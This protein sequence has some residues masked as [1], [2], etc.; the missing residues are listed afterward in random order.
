M[1]YD[2]NYDPELEQK[3]ITAAKNSWADGLILAP[4]ANSQNREFYKKVA[5]SDR[6]HFPAISLE[7]DLVACG[8]DSVLINGRR[9]AYTATSHLLELDCRSILHIQSPTITSAS[10]ERFSGV[11]RC[12]A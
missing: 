2:S 3:Y 5:L 9:A 10:S 1:F 6:K 12:A 7:S 4:L 8:F 11:F